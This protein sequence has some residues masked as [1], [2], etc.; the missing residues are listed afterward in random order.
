M[1]TRKQLF[2]VL[3]VALVGAAVVSFVK[4]AEGLECHYMGETGG[5]ETRYSF[6]AGCFVHTDQMHGAYFVP[7]RWLRK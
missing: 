7:E 2:L 4:T 3:V 6:W 5:F 1:S